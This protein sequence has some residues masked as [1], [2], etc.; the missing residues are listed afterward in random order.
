M[1]GV[2]L[3]DSNMSMYGL[4]LI[5]KGK[6]QATSSMKSLRWGEHLAKE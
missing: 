3:T 6:R 5:S 4:F 2:Y 1:K